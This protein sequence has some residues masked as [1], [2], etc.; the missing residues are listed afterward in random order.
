[1]QR[2]IADNLT[3]GGEIFHQTSDTVGGNDQT[4]FDLGAVYD[5]SEHY[6]CSFRQARHSKPASN[7][8]AIALRILAVDLLKTGARQRADP[9]SQVV[10]VR[11]RRAENLRSGCRP[12]GVHSRPYG[13]RKPKRTVMPGVS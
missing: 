8:P 13:S 5:L 7:K 3:V 4:G 2:Q 9:E 10:P 12:S 11:S 6:H 1:V